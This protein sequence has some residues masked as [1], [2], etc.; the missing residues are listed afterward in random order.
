MQR[1]LGRLGSIALAL[2]L[3]GVIWVVAARE[4]NP[5]IRGRF[6]DTIPVEVTAPP[7]GLNCGTL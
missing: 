6:S 7:A 4:E 5:I 3:A 1:W 2:A